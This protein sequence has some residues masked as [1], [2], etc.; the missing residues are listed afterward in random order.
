MGF[1]RERFLT[2]VA[3]GFASPTRTPILKRP[4]DIGL[5][6]EDVNFISLDGVNL[7]GWFIPAESEK[8]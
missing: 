6:Y 4:S 1:I 7:E 3:K 5:A 2:M 8:W